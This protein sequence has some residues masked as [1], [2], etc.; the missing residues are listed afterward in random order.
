MTL[1]QFIQSMKH[2]EVR[3][4]NLEQIR[5]KARLEVQVRLQFEH[6]ICAHLE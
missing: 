3:S 4:R 2:Y 5:A 1:I 6:D